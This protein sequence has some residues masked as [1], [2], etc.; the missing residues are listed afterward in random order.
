MLGGLALSVLVFVLL[1]TG[2]LT[3]VPATAL[4]IVFFSLLALISGGGLLALAAGVLRANRSP[5]LAD[6]WLCCGELAG[7]GALGALLTSLVTF[8]TTSLEVG[9]YI[10]VALSFFFLFLFFGGLLC[11]LRRYVTACFSSGC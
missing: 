2:T 9:L 7:V 6:A 1:F 10:G 8:L 4:G 5:A 3:L 11:F